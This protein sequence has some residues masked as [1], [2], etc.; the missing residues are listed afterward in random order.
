[1]HLAYTP[2]QDKLAAELRAYFADL[3]TAERR[4]GLARSDGD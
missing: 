3:M 4:A 1:M 2:E